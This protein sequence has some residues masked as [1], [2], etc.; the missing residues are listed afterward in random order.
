LNSGGQEDCM[1]R[2]RWNA[3]ILAA[4]SFVCGAVLTGYGV[5]RIVEEGAWTFDSPAWDAAS[6]LMGAGL[7][8][9]GLVALKPRGAAG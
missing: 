6:M 3:R 8:W 5:Y 1:T 7:A 4:A 2:Q 9:K